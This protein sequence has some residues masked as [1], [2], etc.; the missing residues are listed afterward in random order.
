M[1]VSL[2]FVGIVW[3]YVR[4]LLRLSVP[5]LMFVGDLFGLYGGFVAF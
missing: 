5:F 1:E 3:G 4:L 2:F